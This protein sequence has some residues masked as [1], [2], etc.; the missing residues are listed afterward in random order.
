MG[1]RGCPRA[2]PSQEREPEPR[3]Y[4]A[5]SELPSARRRELLC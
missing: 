5:A 3:D 4:M 1:T 2:T